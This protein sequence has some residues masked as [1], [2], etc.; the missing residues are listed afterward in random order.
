MLGIIF[1]EIRAH[2][3][4]RIR[5]AELFGHRPLHEPHDAVAHEMAVFVIGMLRQAAHGQHGIAC[6]SQVA[7]RIEQ[8][9]VEVEYHKSGIHLIFHIN[10]DAP[11]Y[12]R[13]F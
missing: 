13:L 4:D 3:R 2:G 12:L 1:H 7:D 9:A 8:R 6:D 5:R 10:A 11:Q